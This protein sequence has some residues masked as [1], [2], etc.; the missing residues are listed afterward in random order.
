M[1]L[2]LSGKIEKIME[3]QQMFSQA[4]GEKLVWDPFV[5]DLQVR[6]SWNSNSLEGNTLSLDETLA[7]IEYD[8]VRT[9]H[10]YTEYQEA[11]SMYQAVT[12]KLAFSKNVTID[13]PWIKE[14]NGLIMQ[15]DGRFRDRNVY[16]GSLAEA[17]YYPPDQSKVPEAMD[18]FAGEIKEMPLDSIREKI[19]FIAVKHIEFERIHPFCDGNG[20]TGRMI[21]NQQLLNSGILPAIILDQS[22]YQ[23]AFRRYERNGDTE[24]MEYIVAQGVLESYKKLEE[25]YNKFIQIDRG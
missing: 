9:G 4:K 1:K 20:R 25:I 22:K 8:E 6:L 2:D 15:S 18:R 14:V 7:V 12:E 11:K 10:T 23:Q 19:A 3:K 5:K 16:V 24:L 17:T 13:L 21:M